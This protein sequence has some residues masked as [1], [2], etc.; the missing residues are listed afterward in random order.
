MAY[1]ARR[2]KKLTYWPS[3]QDQYSNNEL[4]S[5]DAI[6]RDLTTSGDEISWWKIDNLEDAE[7]VGLSFVSK[8]DEGTGIIYIV[9]IPFDDISSKLN[10]K[11]TPEHGETAVIGMEQNH[12]DIYN[13]NYKTLG[14][15]GDL[16]ARQ[17]SNESHRYI[18]SFKVKKLI[19]KLG[20]FIDEGKVNVS[21]LGKYA[22]S[23]LKG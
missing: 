5:A 20:Q 4:I 19:E 7:D 22:V 6:T 21:K 13:L 2:L 17:T 8:L 1:L 14:V 15:L 12:Y 23:K 3:D 16:V 10:I 11:N 9:M 18:A